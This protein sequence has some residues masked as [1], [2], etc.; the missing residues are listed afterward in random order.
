MSE[1]VTINGVDLD[2]P[3]PTTTNPSGSISGTPCSAS[4][5]PGFDSPPTN[6]RSTRASSASPGWGRPRS[7]ARRPI[8]WAGRCICSSARWTRVRRISSSRRS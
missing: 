4:K 7:P 1:R 8:A 6:R 2:S 3:H 5:P